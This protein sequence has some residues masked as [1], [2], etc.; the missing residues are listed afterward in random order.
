M[1]DNTPTN[2]R[3]TYR[4]GATINMGDFNNIK[5]EFEISADVPNGVSPTEVK[6]K[7]VTTAEAWLEA[8]I[9]AN[10]GKRFV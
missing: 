2:V 10:A 4:I 5:P 6:N 7:L 1:A 8:N 9:E 3:V